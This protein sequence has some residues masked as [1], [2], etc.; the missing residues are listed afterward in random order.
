MAGRP[1]RFT[2]G[3]DDGGGSIECNQN[4]APSALAGRLRRFPVSVAVTVAAVPLVA[5]ARMA[6]AE[7]D[8]AQWSL[9]AYLPHEADALFGA[10]R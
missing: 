3:V 10:L 6:H 2:P 5:T 7:P 9:R 4:V 8:T 1:S